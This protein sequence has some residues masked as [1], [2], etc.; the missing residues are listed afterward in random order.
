MAHPQ[1]ATFA[2]LADGAAKAIRKIEGQRTLLGRTMHAIAYDEIHDEFSVPVPLP[3]A[4]LTFRGAAN[5]E[6]A[7]IRILQGPKTQLVDPERLATD[8]VHSEI[9]VPQGNSVLVFARDA[10]GDVAPIRILKGPDTELGA[11]AVGVDTVHNLLIVA[12]GGQGGQR[13]RIFNRTDNGNVKP[14]AVIG[15][16]KSELRSIGG[17]FAIYSPKGWIVATVRGGE[18]L[19]SD[20]GF[21]GI[22]SVNDN[23]DVPPRWKVGGPK[24]VFQQPRGVTLDPK[25]KTIIAS[26]KRLNAVLSFYFPEM[27]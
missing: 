4:I 19:A 20:L 23:G 6:E 2:R 24:G 15:G 8:P 16:P 14:K 21:I 11:S 13:F 7:P 3:Q 25:N 17:P 5:G 12:G 1:I 18:G 22:W 27:F 9:F 26:D 10:N